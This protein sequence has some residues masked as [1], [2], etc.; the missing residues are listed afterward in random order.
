MLGSDLLLSRR[1]HLFRVEFSGIR[2]EK[3][4]SVKVVSNMFKILSTSTIL[5]AV[6]G[7]HHQMS[8]MEGGMSQMIL[9]EVLYYVGS[10]CF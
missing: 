5:T 7:Y 2:I 4:L 6:R 1:V 3:D 10:S 9:T 8:F